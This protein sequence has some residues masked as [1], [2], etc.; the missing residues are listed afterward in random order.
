[1]APHFPRRT[2]SRSVVSPAPRGHLLTAKS[3]TGSHATGRMGTKDGK[4]TSARRTTISACVGQS[5]VTQRGSVDGSRLPTP[6]TQAYYGPGAALLLPVDAAP[7]LLGQLNG[8]IE[9]PD[10]M[11]TARKGHGDPREQLDV[12]ASKLRFRYQGG[13]KLGTIA[14]F[15]PLPSSLLMTLVTCFFLK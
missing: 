1:M 4:N 10:R 6:S 12:R 14:N 8:L 5:A 7:D 3:S 11:P 15:P 2:P 13:H 9:I